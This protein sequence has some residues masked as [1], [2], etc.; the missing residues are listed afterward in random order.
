[1]KIHDP[2]HVYPMFVLRSNEVYNWHRTSFLAA[3]APYSGDWLIGLTYISSC[4]LRLD[5]EAMRVAV[6][7][8]LGLNLCEPHTCRCGTMVDTRGLH[9]FVRKFASGRT[10]RHHTLNDTV[11]RAFSSAGIPATKKPVDLSCLDGRRPDG[12]TL[13][14]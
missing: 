10:A 1:M 14:P 8:R 13:V 6:G 9:S 7:V 12:L 2:G 5:D 4:G 3:A 11:Y